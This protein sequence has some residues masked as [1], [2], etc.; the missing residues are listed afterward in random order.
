MPS[1]GVSDEAWVKLLTTTVAVCWIAPDDE[2]LE[3]VRESLSAIEMEAPDLVLMILG[4]TEAQY[5][6]LDKFE[7][8]AVDTLRK[9]RSS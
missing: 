5:E 6:T 2:L 8:E 3:T 7:R 1:L 4:I 9:D